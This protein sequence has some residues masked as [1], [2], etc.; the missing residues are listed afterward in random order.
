MTKD[1]SG[2]SGSSFYGDYLGILYIAFDKKSWNEPNALNSISDTEFNLSR[3]ASGKVIN[4]ATKYAEVGSIYS[5]DQFAIDFLSEL[6]YSARHHTAD[7][8][9]YEESIHRILDALVEF[10]V[11]YLEGSTSRVKS[12]GHLEES[13][14]SNVKVSLSRSLRSSLVNSAVQSLHDEPAEN[15]LHT[16]STLGSVSSSLAAF[17]RDTSSQGTLLSSQPQ[18][19][20]NNASVSNN[21]KKADASGHKGGCC[22]IL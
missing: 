9:N 8:T 14:S 21:A 16:L 2:S 15:T 19:S 18:V 13:P 5:S 17:S 12:S 6:G 11:H 1:S 3:T 22:N 20:V 7:P 4:I 10:S